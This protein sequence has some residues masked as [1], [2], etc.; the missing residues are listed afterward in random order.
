MVDIE[1]DAVLVI[2]WGNP[3]RE[4]DGLAWHVLEGLRRL[5]PRPGLP[6]LHL[7]H[8]HQLTPELAEPVSR[9]A[10]VVFVDARRDGPVGAIRCETVEPAS[11]SNPLAHSLSPQ[12][13]LL[14]AEAL[15]GRAPRAVVV[16][17]SG[18][19]FGLGEELSPPVRRALPWAI[20]TVLRQASRW[21]PAP[22]A[23][24]AEGS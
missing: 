12:G 8:A 17:I 6:P 21:S 13:V 5:R 1:A 19:R 7:R 22:V 24:E 3:L 23:R 2:A 18:E 16:S 4:D 9:A 15:Y 14:Y 20:R 11:G 10:G